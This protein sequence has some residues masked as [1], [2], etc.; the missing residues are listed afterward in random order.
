MSTIL[1]LF[2]G[3][4]LG[5]SIVGLGLV[6]VTGRPGWIQG[7]AAGCVIAGAGLCVL[8]K[9]MEDAPDDQAYT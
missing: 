3:M 5:M 4:V 7:L 2:G 9:L 6:A 1:A 8:G